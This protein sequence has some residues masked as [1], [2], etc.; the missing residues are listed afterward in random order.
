MTTT[1]PSSTGTDAGGQAKSTSPE[2]SPTEPPNPPGAK[3]AQR[4]RRP[5][6]IGLGIALIVLGG[7]FGWWFDARGESQTVLVAT[8]PIQAG[9]PVKASQL[10]TTEISGGQNTTTIPVMHRDDIAGQMASSNIPAGT[11]LNPDQFVTSVEPDEG[12]SITGV[13]VTAA[14]MPAL[15][16]KP[17]DTVTVV[18]TASDQGAASAGGS[19][20]S[21]DS[22]GGSTG[23]VLQTGQKWR[24]TVASVGEPAD[25]GVRTV[26]VTLNADAAEAL[27]S[28]GG[29]G[30]L[31]IV[32]NPS[33]R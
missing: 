10:G 33:A 29:S 18:V 21:E 3:T 9:E 15:G 27:A 4:R 12:M 17:G 25:D 22:S 13:P 32:L 26:D 14:Q 24:A 16:L 31:A 11:V 1:V 6:L 20:N 23:D 2:R 7:L 19:G 30:R 8:G 5:K 28:A